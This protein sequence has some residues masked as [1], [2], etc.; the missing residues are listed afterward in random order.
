MFRDTRLKDFSCFITIS[1]KFLLF[2]CNFSPMIQPV[3][4]KNFYDPK[5]IRIKSFQW[6]ND[7]ISNLRGPQRDFPTKTIKKQIMMASQL[8]ANGKG[9][10]AVI[11]KS[12]LSTHNWYLG[13]R[14]RW[15]TRLIQGW[16][17]NDSMYELIALLPVHSKLSLYQA[18]PFPHPLAADYS[19]IT[20]PSN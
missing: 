3:P 14:F 19:N 2:C 16:W 7:K 12:P 18:L 8:L 1:G 9:I 13:K 10:W 6:L 20:V 15:L 4:F 11:E 5:K 17:Q